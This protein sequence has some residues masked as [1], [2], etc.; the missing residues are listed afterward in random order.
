MFD[1]EYLVM[2]KSI[3]LSV[4][5]SHLVCGSFRDEPEEYLHSIDLRYEANPIEMGREGQEVKFDFRVFGESSQSLVQSLSS[6]SSPSAHSMS[7]EAFTRW[8]DLGQEKRGGPE[9]ATV[10]D[11]SND[12]FKDTD[13]S[14]PDRLSAIF[15]FPADQDQLSETL[16]K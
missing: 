2:V 5:R 4:F 16:S 8:F 3:G 9:R 10:I 1:N 13:G 15:W 12:V 14:R 11:E 6:A 7:L